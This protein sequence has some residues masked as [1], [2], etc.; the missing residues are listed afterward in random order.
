MDASIV[1]AATALV[2][3]VLLD[4]WFRGHDLEGVAVLTALAF[5]VS[6]LVAVVVG[7]R[8]AFT[9]DM[10]SPSARLVTAAL[11]VDLVSTVVYAVTTLRGQ[12]AAGDPIDAAL[13]ATPVLWGAAAL[14]PSMRHL[15][16]ASE[17]AVE[18]GRTRIALLAAAV[19]AVPA[20]AAGQALRGQPVPWAAVAVGGAAVGLLV[21]Y[22]L[23][24]VIAQ[25]HE[26]SAA[27]EEAAA[28]FR[29][30][31][32][33]ARDMIFRYRKDPSAYEYVSPSVTAV[34]GRTPEEAYADP[35]F[36]IHHVE[37]DDLAR[38]LSTIA[39]DGPDELTHTLRWSHADGRLL[40]LD[41]SI[42]RIRDES[43]AVV[44][45]EGII[46]DITERGGGA[47]AA[48][49]RPRRARAGD[50]PP[51]RVPRARLTRAPD[52]AHAAHRLPR[53]PPEAAAGARRAGGRRDARGDGASGAAARAPRHRAP[54]DD[55]DHRGDRKSVV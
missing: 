21:L 17:A 36:A 42:V 55:R 12:Y 8:A 46:R 50:P 5:P 38:L 45:V 7:A 25:L 26:K 52:P 35:D 37:D 53:D 27:L 44:R 43:G 32:D 30:L 15:G 22:R 1:G 41:E 24:L 10:R 20:A 16:S 4:P 48:R 54:H 31:T 23:A 34:L 29:L 9:V 11:L 13:L 14:H 19:V 39:D 49:A 51:R 40:W 33:N 47:A 6:S 18:R 2:A 28:S 3:S